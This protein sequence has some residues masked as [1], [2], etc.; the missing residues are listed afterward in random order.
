MHVWAHT[1]MHTHTR[2]RSLKSVC[3]CVWVCDR[4]RTRADVLYKAHLSRKGAR[5]IC[6][7]DWS[8]SWAVYLHAEDASGRIQRPKPILMSPEPRGT[9]WPYRAFPSH[10]WKIK[11][12]TYKFFKT[13]WAITKRIKPGRSQTEAK[14][15]LE[16]N[17]IAPEG[18]QA[19]DAR[20][21]QSA[22]EIR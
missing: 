22:Q 7:S 10:Q 3:V 12:W 6:F 2:V 14:D 17:T 4:E 5:Q 1:H 9:V 20:R 19:N 18:N 16:T 15:L 8:I 21:P 11:G 13:A